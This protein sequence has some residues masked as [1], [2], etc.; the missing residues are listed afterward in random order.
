MP[1]GCGGAACGEGRGLRRCGFDGEHHLPGLELVRRV[2]AGQ[3]VVASR[4][5]PEADAV[6]AGNE[7][8]GPSSSE[9]GT[10]TTNHGITRRSEKAH[11]VGDTRLEIRQR[12]EICSLVG[13][14]S[15]DADRRR[16]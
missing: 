10:Y 9:P 8:L 16:V 13:G 5:V 11:R 4:D 3:A 2:I 1:T 6:A 7:R 12:V 14:I 15:L